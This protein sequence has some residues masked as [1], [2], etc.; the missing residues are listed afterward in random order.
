MNTG[1][2]IL[3]H[4]YNSDIKYVGSTKKLGFKQRFNNH[5]KELKKNIHNNTHLQSVANKYGVDGFRMDIILKCNPSYC[6][7]AEQF[8]IDTLDTYNNGYNQSKMAGCV[9]MPYEERRISTKNQQKIIYQIDKNSKII[10]KFNGILLAGREV[11]VNARD[12]SSCC[13]NRVNMAGGYLWCFEKDYNKNIKYKSNYNNIGVIQFD[14]NNNFIKEWNSIQE[15]AIKYSNGHNGN[16]SN[17]CSGKLKSAY[18][19][20]WKYKTI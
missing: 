19:Y 4:I 10:N 14:K 5:I 1:V 9:S 3:Y 15:A 17:C 2:Y 13:N 11:G 7:E 20:I 16:I 12:I 8:W 18:G 6:I